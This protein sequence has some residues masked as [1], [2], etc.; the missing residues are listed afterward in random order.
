MR[1]LVRIV[2]AL[3]LVAG[4]ACSD[5]DDDDEA[6][7]GTETDTVAGGIGMPG[8]GKVAWHFIGRIDQ[9]ALKFTAYGFLTQVDGLEEGD[10]FTTEGDRTEDT[11]V[12]S[13]VMESEESSRSKLNNVTV[14][15]VTGTASIYV[16]EKPDRTFGDPAS[17]ATG[18]KIGSASVS[19][20]NIL[21]ID[22]EN[23]DKGVAAAS[24][25]LRQTSA[26]RFTLGGT[27]RQ[28]G[29]DGLTERLTLSGQ[30]VRSDATAPKST[31]EVAGTMT[32]TG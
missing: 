10:L 31:I 9:D 13:V 30:G 20:Q 23:R 5:D 24:A 27:E 32:I 17:F 4:A 8:S 26:T 18:T 29:R 25:E 6:T 3:L 7:G 14:V 19:G 15:D 28:L 22:P 12:F 21:N 2:A 11:A 1:G 16:N